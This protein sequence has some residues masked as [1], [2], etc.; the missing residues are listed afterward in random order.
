M[1]PRLKAHIA[2]FLVALIYGA[3][4]TIAKGV[5]DDE[6]MQPLGFILLRVLSGLLFFT[7]IHHFFIKEKV[8]RKDFGLL[9]L[10]GLFG[11]AINQMFFFMGLKLTKPIN[12]SLIM[13]TCPIIVLVV[14]A[15]I[16]KEAITIRKLVGICFGAAGAILL[17]L[18]GEKVSFDRDQILGDVLIFINASSYAVYLVLV[19]SLM[20]KYHPITVVKWVFTIGIIFVLPF[21]IS[22]LTVVEWQTFPVSIWIAVAYVLICTTIL[23][24]LFNTYALKIVRA[25][26]VSIYIYLQPLLATLVA[27]LADSD[28]FVPQKVVF[29]ILIFIGVYLVSSKKEVSKL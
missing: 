10:C 16:L 1:S 25:S 9:I 7:I 6:Y 23:A 14:S 8:E 13:T 18:Y 5:L 19:K 20:K 27:L 3:N 15:I 26:T 17:I 21:G 4:Y 29:G 12:A 28:Q 24:Y 11:V 2:L 22:K